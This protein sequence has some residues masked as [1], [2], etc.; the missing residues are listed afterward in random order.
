MSRD[1]RGRM[2]E[3]PNAVGTLRNEGKQTSIIL[4]QWLT[5]QPKS[6]RFLNR[7]KAMID[8]DSDGFGT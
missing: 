6:P 1:M 2:R 8:P 4:E 7:L 5:S 3:S